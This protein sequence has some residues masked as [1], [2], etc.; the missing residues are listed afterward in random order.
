[1]SKGLK[2]YVE[3]ALPLKRCSFIDGSASKHSL[4]NML[5]EDRDTK[6]MINEKFKVYNPSQ[7]TVAYD[8]NKNLTC[9]MY[10]FLRAIII[11]PFKFHGDSHF[12]MSWLSYCVE[13]FV[14]LELRSALYCTA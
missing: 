6:N 2:P 4:T 7:K 8:N 13:V 9:K 14:Q 11:T 3:A 12:E 10:T 5:L 1:M